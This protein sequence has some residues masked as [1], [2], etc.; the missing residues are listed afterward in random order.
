MRWLDRAAHGL[1]ALCM[2]LAALLTA[3]IAVAVVYT[4][5]ARF[6]FSRT[7][8]WT[9]ELPRILM[10]WAVFLGVVWTTAK[11]TNLEAG[12]LELW[13]RGARLRAAMRLIAEIL[14]AAFCVTLAMT[15][16]EMADI[17]WFT[18]TPALELTAAIFYLPI[19]IGGAL[20]ALCQVPRILRQALLLAG[21][22]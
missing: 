22:A 21:R 4:V 6:A 16:A 7:P 14:V 5:A 10:I 19:A 12:L 20:A 18:I 9:E 17:T 11:G 1:A 13:T 3:A 2:G 15:A 8:A